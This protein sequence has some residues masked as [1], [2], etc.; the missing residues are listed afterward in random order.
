MPSTF[1]DTKMQR[2]PKKAPFRNEKLFRTTQSAYWLGLIGHSAAIIG[3]Y[4]LGVEIL[5]YFNLFFSV[6]AFAVALVLNKRGAYGTAFTFAF[7]ELLLHQVLTTYYLGWEFGSHYW[8]IYLA[9]LS[10]F[11]PS[12][13]RKIQLIILF[14]VSNTWVALYF[15]CQYGVLQGQ[16][17]NLSISYPVN[18]VSSL[19]ALAVL[20]NYFSQSAHRAERE[21]QKKQSLTRKMLDKIESLFG[22]QIS[23][24]IAQEMIESESE[25]ES[26][27]FDATVMFLDIRD[28]TMFADSRAPEE[29]AGFQNMVFGEL[30]EIVRINKGVVLQL[31]GDGIMAVFGAPKTDTRHAEQ[32][33]KAGFSMINKIKQLSIEGKIPEIRVGIGL[34]SGDIVAGN[35]GNDHR[36]SY[37]LTGKNVIIA[38]RIEQLNKQYSSQFLIS[39]STK[40]ASGNLKYETEELGLVH[41]KGIENDVRIFKLD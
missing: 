12:W 10:F 22:Q 15:F 33:V 11:N 27:R 2:F 35:I 41:L 18:G 40:L 17:E 39:E 30:I 25:I 20:I 19:V 3:F 37:S 29:V 23:E 34:N 7:S 32:A 26:R 9:G 13:S 14:I 24:E 38:A 5:V 8:L 1:H 36:K 21:L 4:N 31:L 6:P 28:F 16:V